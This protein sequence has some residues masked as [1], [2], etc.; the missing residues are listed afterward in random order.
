MPILKI[1]NKPYRD[2]KA[3]ATVVN[4][5]LNTSC[6]GGLFVDPNHAVEQMRLVKQLWYKTEGRQVRHFYVSFSDSEGV[7]IDEAFEY[8]YKI[9]RYYADRFQIVFGV[10][11]DTLHIHIHFAVNT[12]SYI[13]GRMYS[14]SWGNYAE[15]RD[16]IQDL[17]PEGWKVTLTP[18]GK[19]SRDDSAWKI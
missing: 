4:Y 17:M 10:H 15:L 16:F 6:V 18:D 8:G 12:V 14:G 2:D 19:N 9:A 7:S 5:V 13:D 3:L 1:K 11:H